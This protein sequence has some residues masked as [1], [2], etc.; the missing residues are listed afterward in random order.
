VKHQTSKN[1]TE[2]ISPDNYKRLA[3]F[4]ILIFG[5]IVYSNS[6]NGIFIL[7]DLAYIQNN[8]DIVNLD[9]YKDFSY[10][11]SLQHRPVP[12]YTFA[13]NYILHEFEV[14]GYHIVNIFLHLVNALLIFF[15]CIKLFGFEQNNI[16]V[17][18]NK[19]LIAAVVSILYLSH[20]V[21]TQTVNYIVQRMTIMAALFYLLSVLT[22]IVAR[23][24][25]ILQNRSKALIYYFFTLVAF[26][27]AILSKQTAIT[28][29]VSLLIVE[30][31]FIRNNEG[32]KANILIY[33]ASI[34]LFVGFLI[35]VFGGYLPKENDEISRMEYFSTQ[36]GVVLIY[37]KTLIYPFSLNFDPHVEI[38]KNMSGIREM[39]FFLIHLLIIGI[40][41]FF[42]RKNKFVTFGILWFYITLSVESTLIPIRDVIFDHRLYLPSFGFVLFIV[43]VAFY[44]VKV[45]L[46]YILLA[47]ALLFSVYAVYSYNRNKIWRDEMRFWTDVVNQPPVKAR[48]YQFLGIQYMYKGQY[49][50]AI[51]LF[52]NSIDLAPDR[53]QEHN[54]KAIAYIALK[55]YDDAIE[56][57]G[58]CINLQPNN[59]DHYLNRASLLIKMNHLEKGKSDLDEAK[60]HIDSPNKAL[61]HKTLGNYFFAMESYDSAKINF[62]KAQNLGINNLDM[63]NKLGLSN[64][65]LANFDEAL[66]NF[67]TIIEL[68]KTYNLAYLN[69]GEAY[70]FL[71][72]YDNSIEDFNEFLAI[73]NQSGR[74]YYMRGMSHVNKGEIG[75]ALEDLKVADQLGNPVDKE[76]LNQ[77]QL[78]TLNNE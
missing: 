56:Q 39:F 71:K 57:Y 32:K 34:I 38:I 42:V 3:V 66:K 22:Y 5:I 40:S 10:W 6:L 31:I 54:N 12:T 21:Q 15:L 18:E 2:L 62:N 33:S 36:L 61:Y 72:D 53:W 11:L 1:K 16:R 70:F 49:Y 52:D 29:P 44:Y 28:I 26:L 58:N 67:S 78:Y 35:V 60:L 48:P 41:I 64:L 74:A 59:P 76:F 50:K 63:L 69:R 46:K 30:A 45:Q 19:I 7:D 27:L 20:P 23:Q 47:G 51:E 4:F 37:L 73:N 77:L 8:K 13:L 9:V 55:K 65:R 24:Y 25:H 68:D 17:K 14:R 43:V 75:K